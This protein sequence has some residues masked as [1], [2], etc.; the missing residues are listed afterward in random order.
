MNNQEEINLT[1]VRK[2]KVRNVYDLGQNY[3]IVASDRISAFDNIIPTIIPNKG[4]ILH[5]LSMFWFDFIQGIIPNHLITGDF[6]TFPVKLKQYDYLRDRAMI[7]KKANKINI[8]CIVRGYITG[9]AW[10]EYQKSETFCGINLPPGLKESSRLPNPIFTPS[11]KNENSGHDVNI[12]FADMVKEV[13]EEIAYKLQEISIRLYKKV[14][15]YSLLKG[16]IVADTKLE[17]GFYDDQLMLID[18]LFTPDSSRF[19]EI[20]EY[21]DGR[22]QNSLDKQYVRDYLEFIKWDKVSPIPVLPKIIIKKTL[23]KYISVYERL[24]GKKF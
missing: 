7:V 9:S 21:K 14:N 2:G 4:K 8:E 17:F 24:T 15:E 11:T 23:E 13:G 6:N 10:R 22:S 12:S 19:W 20:C 16:I 18:E 1:L 5:K 3:L